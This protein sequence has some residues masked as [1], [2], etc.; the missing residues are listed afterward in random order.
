MSTQIPLS[1]LE[2]YSF[3]DPASGKSVIKRV[4]A[5]SSI[6]VIGADSI[7]RIFV[8][9]AWAG[10][11]TTPIL[12]KKLIDVGDRYKGHL[13]RFGI[14]AN[15]MQSLFADL[16]S[17]QAKELQ[18][19]IPF[20]PIMQ[21]TKVDKDWRIRTTLQP[22]MNADSGRLFVHETHHELKSELLSFPMGATK[23]LVDALASAVRLV[24]RRVS[25]ERSDEQ[26]QAL[27]SYLRESGLSPQQI[28]QRLNEVREEELALERAR[29]AISLDNSVG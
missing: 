23:D 28:V 4:R 18:R 7:N 22:L 21:P 26:Q 2:V 16:V 5:R 27:A 9:M 19:K 17:S 25:S 20:V 12:V 8:L 15:A 10:R 1:E 13:R 6:V 3:C 24:P 29:A 11:P 14:E